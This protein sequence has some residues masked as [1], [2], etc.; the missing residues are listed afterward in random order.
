M[1]KAKWISIGK[2]FVGS[3]TAICCL[4]TLLLYVF[5]DEIC[6]YVIQHVNGYLKTEVKVAEVD[7]T[8]WATFPNLSVDF[9]GV[10]I[11]DAFRKPSKNDTLF[12]SNQIRLKF[13]PWDIWNE[14]YN[15][16]S[17]DISEGQLH[18]KVRKNGEVNYDIF[19][20]SQKKKSD[21][22]LMLQGLNVEGVALTYDNAI[23]DQHYRSDI[24]ELLLR[25]EF[26]QDEFDLEVASNL[27]INALKSGKVTLLSNQSADCRFT[28]HINNK[29]STYLLPP[30]TISIAE[31]PF[32]VQ[33]EINRDSI[34]FN[35]KANNLSFED[36]VNKLRIAGVDQISQFQGKGKVRFDLN[37]NG[38]NKTDA[39]VSMACHFGVTNGSLLDPIKKLR[40][41]NIQ[42]QGSYEKQEGKQEK[43]SFKQFRLNTPAGPFQG[44][45]DITA[46]SN[47]HFVGSARGNLNMG[48]V[49]DL[50]SLPYVDQI[51]GYLGLNTDFDVVQQL[52]QSAGTVEIRRCQGEVHLKGIDAQL[53]NDK[54]V[55][56]KMKGK[57]YLRNDEAGMEGVSLEVG[58]S[59]LA[60][61]GV[62]KNIVPYL[63]NKGDI[64]AE[65][66]VNSKNIKVEDLGV[67][68]KQEKINQPK[69]Y[70]LPD[71]IDARVDLGVRSLFYDKHRLNNVGS[72]LTVKGR[73][74]TFQNLRARNADADV[75]GSMTVEERSPEKFYLTTDVASQN[76][77][78]KKLFK[79]W[80]NFDQEV[81]T[82]DNIVG[83]AEAN[84][85][86]EAPFDFETGV[87]SNDI[88]SQVY[89]KVVNG[90]L[91]NVEALQSIVQS[92]D[93]RMAKA[94]LG[95]ENIKRLSQKLKQLDFNTL[96]NTFEINNGVL[97]IPEM[98]VSS[99]VLDMLVSGKHTFDNKVDY[100]FTFRFRDLKERKQTEFGEEIDDGTGLK[101]YM[102]MTG[103]LDNPTITWDKD[104]MKQDAKERREQEKETIKS[105][106]KTEFG[107]F[108]ND[109]TV[110]RYNSPNGN[111]ETISIDIDPSQPAQKP[112]EKKKPSKVKNKLDQW[113]NQSEQDKKEQIEFP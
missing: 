105:M 45:L 59:D 61:D 90:K 103:D 86:F 93:S 91:S 53:K 35:L 39:P 22:K 87:I 96:E 51:N 77:Q 75:V 32:T 8:F 65:V 46:F 83:N 68:T 4:I 27:H 63:Q 70:V 31:L 72:Q 62:F 37:V 94:V 88:K 102:R 60:L 14:N 47:P 76:I 16:K 54:R 17:I 92:L 57:L 18:L 5:K 42:L 108:K 23:S 67:S 38:K 104:A 34:D 7:L 55:F 95:K 20:P 85:H 109:S 100:R 12:S 21:F 44:K 106:L 107:L 52:S 97:E 36:A 48:F 1:T 69:D 43:L 64:V 98:L 25:G 24:N 11:R 111:K 2:W 19:K 15:L 74:I 101:V 49:H 73:T 41:S 26:N 9:N 28:M 3:I 79:E 29:H 80:N 10:Y 112:E 30:S 81:I 113:K 13:N 82:H 50:F 84:V 56:R 6:G 33:G 71:D 89:M 66:V 78:F 40:I 99:S 58:S 110:K